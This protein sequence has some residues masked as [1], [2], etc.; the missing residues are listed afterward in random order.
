[1]KKIYIT[2]LALTLTTITKAQSNALDVSFGA[3]GIVTTSISTTVDEGKAIAIQSDGKILVAGYF[4]NFTYNDIAV[5]RYNT[6]GSLDNTFDTD[7]KVTTTFGGNSIDEATCIAIQPDGKILVAGYTNV[8]GNYDFAIVR[9]NT[10]GSLDNT[11]DTDGKVNTD[12]GGNHDYAR[13][14]ALQS[15]GKIVVA[16]GFYAGMNNDDIALVRYNSNGSLDNTFD[17]DGKVITTVNGNV[18]NGNSVAIQSDGKIVV[19]GYCRPVSGQDFIV[20]RYNTNGSLDT[21]FDVDGMAITPIGTGNDSGDEVII[22]SDGK[23]ILVG[24]SNIGGNDDFAMVRYNS[25]GSLDTSFDADGKVTTAFSANDD[26]ARSIAIASDGKLVLAGKTSNG[27]NNDIALA[28]YNTNG[29]LDV[30]FDTDGMVTTAIGTGADEASSV[31]IQ[32]DGKIVVAGISY[33][34]SNNDFAVV[35]YNSIIT[36]L[37]NSHM[38]SE[39][40]SFFPCPAKDNLKISS[41]TAFE[42][43]NNI[44]AIDVLGKEINLKYS[45]NTTNELNLLINELNAGIYII[46][47]KTNSSIISKKIIVSNID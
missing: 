5:L 20:L 35:R 13:G 22:Q 8:G 12:I 23:I 46:N 19:G 39:G 38:P 36:G 31:R 44:T 2:I 15:D 14:I 24:E 32:S 25:D 16:G 3:G 42:N 37:N 21:S 47:I 7:G 30:S 33:N 27:T 40:L 28:R 9:Y 17:G 1:M 18:E 34:G 26:K 43:I 11:F 45:L 10:N 29:S 41:L 4:L 6:D